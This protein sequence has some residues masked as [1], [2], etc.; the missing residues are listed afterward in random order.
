MQAAEA[1]TPT[2]VGITPSGGSAAAL[3]SAGAGDS[4]DL[5]GGGEFLEAQ[6]Q[7]QAAGGSGSS[8]SAVT[9]RPRS[10]HAPTSSFDVAAELGYNQDPPAPEELFAAM[11]SKGGTPQAAPIEEDDEGLGAVHASGGS[12]IGGGG[13]E[14]VGEGISSRWW[15]AYQCECGAAPVL[16][17]CGLQACPQQ[18]RLCLA[19]FIML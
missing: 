15:T 11:V 9:V 3:L 8:D 12:S 18:L 16:R 7:Q 19:A 5:K 1:A 4:E 13:L 10:R 6:Q 2:A 14:G 17:C